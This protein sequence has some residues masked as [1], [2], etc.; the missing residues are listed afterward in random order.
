VV[1]V[2]VFQ[3][4]PCLT[5]IKPAKFRQAAD[6]PGPRNFY[7]LSEVDWILRAYRWS[8]HCIA[9]TTGSPFNPPGC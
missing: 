3:P 4:T 8:L 7:D 1:V 2:S 9:L 5:P 6:S